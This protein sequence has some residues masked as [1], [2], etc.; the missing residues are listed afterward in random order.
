MKYI[1]LFD[2]FFINEQVVTDVLLYHGSNMSFDEFDDNKISSGDGSDLFGKGYYLTD[3]KKVAEFYAKMMT[4]KEKITNYTPTGIFGTSDPHYSADADEYADKNY[5]INVFKIHANILNVKTYILDDSFVK[6]LRN[7][8][9]KVYSDDVKYFDD[10]ILF[11]RGN[12]EKIHGFR[13]EIWYIIYGFGF[14]GN[15]KNDL[16]SYIK[17]LGYDGLKYESDKEYENIDSWNYVIYNK[18]V[19]KK[20]E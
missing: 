5:H 19:I 6:I 9:K 7:A 18:N 2:N 10:M 4:K 3:N 1:K 17:K 13:G 8:Y 15:M 20:V 11:M 14:L 16:I 12:K